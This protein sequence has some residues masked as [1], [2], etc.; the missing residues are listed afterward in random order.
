MKIIKSIHEENILKENEI[1]C[2]S[3]RFQHLL[4][5]SS[6]A[7]I[8]KLNDWNIEYKYFEHIPLR[9]VEASKSVQDIFLN[10]KKVFKLLN[11][12]N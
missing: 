7:F 6:D 3:S 12:I 10:T 11:I 1:P 8:K 4:P 9:T 5:I 2:A